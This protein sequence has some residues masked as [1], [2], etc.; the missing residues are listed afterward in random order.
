MVAGASLRTVV[1]ADTLAE[2]RRIA[3]ARP[4]HLAQ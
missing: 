3:E 2:A 4:I 1:D